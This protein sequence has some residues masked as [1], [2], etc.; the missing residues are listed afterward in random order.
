MIQ[1]GTIKTLDQAPTRRGMYKYLEYI[2]P[3]FN[4]DLG[5]RTAVVDWRKFK[6]EENLDKTI[7]FGPVWDYSHHK[8]EI[9]QFLQKLTD[10]KAKTI[11]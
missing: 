10:L 9:T 11:N 3:K 5:L 2:L 4:N 7:L 8:E 1:D 6:I